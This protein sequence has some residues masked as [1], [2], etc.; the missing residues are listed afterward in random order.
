MESL[1][2]RSWSARPWAVKPSMERAEAKGMR[3]PPTNARKR[4]LLDME[5]P[6]DPAAEAIAHYTATFRPVL[7]PVRPGT[8]APDL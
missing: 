2:P 4:K 5:A 8:P 3:P 1:F 6:E 7:P